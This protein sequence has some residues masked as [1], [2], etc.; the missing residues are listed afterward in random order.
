MNHLATLNYKENTDA[1]QNQTELSY[2]RK[3]GNALTSELKT[4]INGL[5]DNEFRHQLHGTKH[6]VGAGYLMEPL[7]KA[8]LRPY[9]RVL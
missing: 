7:W 3:H 6:Q 4:V 1:C 2:Q 9:R 8:Y 5:V